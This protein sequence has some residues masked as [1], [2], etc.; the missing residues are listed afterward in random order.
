MFISISNPDPSTI[1]KPFPVPIFIHKNQIQRQCHDHSSRLQE[2]STRAAFVNNVDDAK[3]LIQQIDEYINHHETNQ[4]NALRRLSDAS[5]GL[6]GFDTSVAIYSESITVFDTFLKTKAKLTDYLREEQT[7]ERLLSE[8]RLK[9]PPAQPPAFYQSLLDAKVQEG[10]RFV[11]KCAVRGTPTPNVEWFK[12]GISIQNNSDY[13]TTFNNGLCTLTIE[14]AMTA[15]T[16][17]F[18]CRATNSAGQDET[19]ARLTVT[20][21]IT[22]DKLEA[23][24]FA[25]PLTTSSAKEKLPFTFSC[26]VTGHPLPIVQWFKNNNCIDQL[27]DYTITYNNGQAHLKIN[28]VCLEDQTSFMCRAINPVGTAETIANLIVQRKWEE[29]IFDWSIFTSDSFLATEPG[30]P[31]FFTQPLTNVMAR[32]GQKLIL[33]CIVTGQ[34]VPQLTWKQNNK[35]ITHPEAKVR[36]NLQR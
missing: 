16:A 31:P 5:R 17:N 7:K 28:E 6:F 3:A 27:P 29:Q 34:P 35:P 11:F 15:D 20:E 33:E 14:E 13:Q 18:H 8:E 4:L 26:M 30:E 36:S 19:L 2:I 24:V 32:V 22:A 25:I 10:D 21:N 1:C 12:D 23:P 9:E